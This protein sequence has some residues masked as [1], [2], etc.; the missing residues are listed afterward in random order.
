MAELPGAPLGGIY[1]LNACEQVWGKG[2]CLSV[3]FVNEYK[4]VREKWTIDGV[5]YGMK[6]SFFHIMCYR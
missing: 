5:N 2:K 3:E 1:F 6:L 4:K